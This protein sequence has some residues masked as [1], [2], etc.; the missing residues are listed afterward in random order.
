VIPLDELQLLFKLAGRSTEGSN[1]RVTMFQLRF[2]SKA[3]KRCRYTLTSAYGLGYVLKHGKAGEPG[4]DAR[5]WIARQAGTWNGS[6]RAHH[7]YG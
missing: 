6:Q 7:S 4:T 2:K 1:V 5:G 3:L